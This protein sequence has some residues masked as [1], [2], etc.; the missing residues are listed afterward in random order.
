MGYIPPSSALKFDSNGNVLANINA[1]NITPSVTASNI[2]LDSNGN[3]LANLNAQNIT[4]SVTASNIKLDSNGN[5]LANLN[6]QNITPNVNATNIKFDSNGYVEANLFAQN[7]TPTVTASNIKFDSNGNVLANINAQNINPTIANPYIPTLLSHQT[8][9]SITASTGGTYHAI[10][11]SI[12]V[13][14]N[15][16]VVV[17]MAGHVSAGQ[18][19]IELELTRGSNSFY[20]GNGYHSL[21]SDNLYYSIGSA[22]TKTTPTVLSTVGNYN[23]GN[24]YSTGAQSAFILPVYSGDSL[25]FLATNNT[26]SDI[27]YIDDVLVMLI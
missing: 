9:L 2:K 12:T 27:T 10:G 13:P 22:I 24:S 17:S 7:I 18:G 6:A 20:F 14:R 19:Y 16:I 25:Q 4:P 15:G 21:F 5:V 3:V 11:S 1:Q 26:A 8:G 23:T